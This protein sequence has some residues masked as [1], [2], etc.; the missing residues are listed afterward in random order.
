MAVRPPLKNRR[1]A[2]ERPPAVDPSGCAPGPSSVGSIGFSS[3]EPSS[4]T[5]SVRGR[6]FWGPDGV[7]I[8]RR[9][10]ENP[11]WGSGSIAHLNL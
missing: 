3:S 11:P 4:R 6:G 1:L 10:G 9:G 7:A 5:P 2:R 8:R